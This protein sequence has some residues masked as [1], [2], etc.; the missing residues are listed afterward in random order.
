MKL[1]AAKKTSKNISDGQEKTK[2]GLI[3]KGNITAL[4][5]KE[6]PKFNCKVC[7]SRS[8]ILMI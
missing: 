1:N 3:G 7:N 6:K 4:K 5:L 8:K 2:C